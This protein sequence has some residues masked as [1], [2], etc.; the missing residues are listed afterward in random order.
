[1][2]FALSKWPHLHRAYAVT[3]PFILILAVCTY[4]ITD[5]SETKGL[6]G[7]QGGGRS[8]GRKVLHGG[9]IGGESTRLA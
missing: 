3:V 2:S 7:G 6:G 1:M 9:T 5:E 4:V 8:G